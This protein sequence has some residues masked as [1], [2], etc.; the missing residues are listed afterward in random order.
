MQQHNNI[1]VKLENECRICKCKKI[2][3][4]APEVIIINKKEQKSYLCIECLKKEL[5][6][7]KE[8]YGG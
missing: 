6:E 2:E 7:R 1:I 4:L 8:F 5:I 3:S